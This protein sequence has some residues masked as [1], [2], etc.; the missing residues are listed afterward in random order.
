GPVNGVLLDS[1]VQEV[2]VGTGQVLM[3]WHAREHVSL[4]ESFAP[5][6]SSPSAPYDWFHVNSIE[7]DDDGNLLVSSR[8]AW[9]ICKI[10]RGTGTVLRRLG[11]R[12]SD[13]QFGAGAG[14]AWQHD[15]RRR[16]DGMITLFDN[17]AGLDVEHQSRGLVLELDTV[18]KTAWL[19]GAYPHPAGLT[20]N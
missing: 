20:A 9:T 12:Q 7:V 6:P 16:A 8:H 10:D 11:G 18:W 3:E 5:A 15:A 13:F 14:F 2:D 4:Q 17:G 1:I 19:A